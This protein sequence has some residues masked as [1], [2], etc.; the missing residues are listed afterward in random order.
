MISASGETGYLPTPTFRVLLRYGWIDR[1]NGAADRVP[2]YRL[3][4]AGG[5]LLEPA[6]RP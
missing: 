2:T 1:A 5:Q 3:S 6:P 4:E